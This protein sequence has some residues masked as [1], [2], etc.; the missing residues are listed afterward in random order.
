MNE[1]IILKLYQR[2]QTQRT[3]FCG[4]SKKF[5]WNGWHLR[6]QVQGFQNYQD[7]ASWGHNWT[8][9]SLKKDL[10]PT[11]RREFA[12]NIQLLV[13]LLWTS[14]PFNVH[15]VRNYACVWFVLVRSVMMFHFQLCRKIERSNLSLSCCKKRSFANTWVL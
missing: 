5:N 11:W 13:C 1:K 15:L 7:P 2:I 9:Y 3:R 10:V 14:W 8:V 4:F 12:T 6:F